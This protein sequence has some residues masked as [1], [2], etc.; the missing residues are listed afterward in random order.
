MSIDQLK[1]GL[2]QQIAAEDNVAVLEAMEKAG[3]LH[4]RNVADLERVRINFS[5]HPNL[6]QEFNLQDYID[7]R[8]PNTAPIEDFLKA[9]EELEWET[10]IEEDLAFLKALRK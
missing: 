6:K 4:K 10:T 5:K 9:T 1:L 2:I 7:K 3:R 8:P